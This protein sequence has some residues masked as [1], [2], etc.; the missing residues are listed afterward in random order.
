MIITSK[1]LLVNIHQ[2]SSTYADYVSY[3][4][5]YYARSTAELTTSPQHPSRLR[6]LLPAA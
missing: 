5:N 2:Q 6:R 3:I 4:P 1:C